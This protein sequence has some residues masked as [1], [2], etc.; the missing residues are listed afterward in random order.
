MGALKNELIKFIKEE[1]LETSINITEDLSIEND[2]GISGDD[3]YEFIMTFSKKFQVDI[4]DFDYSE[5]FNSEPSWSG[6]TSKKKPLTVGMLNRALEKR[7][8]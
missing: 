8:F 4:K 3:A 5:Y 1:T 6:A 7:K 2:L